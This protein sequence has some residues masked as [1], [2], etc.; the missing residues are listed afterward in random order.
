MG[1][2]DR[3]HGSVTDGRGGGRF[4]DA[5]R[6]MFG[7]GDNFLNWSFPLYSA[8]G[9]RVRVHLLFVLVVIG[10]LVRSYFG[11]TSG[12]LGV[13]Y[14]AIGLASLFGLVL[15]HE[16]GHCIACRRV[17][18]EA[19][20][21]L[22]WPLGGLASCRPPHD[23]RSH[24]TTTI[25]GPAVNALLFPILGGIVLALT[26]NW[27]AVLFNP[28]SPGLAIPDVRLA[29]SQLQPMWLISLWWLYFMNAALLG[30]NLLPMYPL[31]GG[32]IVQEILWS[33]VGFR[34]SMVIA[35]K[36]GLIGAVVLGVFAVVFGNT[37]LMGVALFA[38]LTCW[39]QGRQIQFELAGEVPGYDFE[40][41][42][43]GMPGAEEEVASG[44][45][46][47]KR[48]EREEAEQTELDR[49]LAKIAKTGMGNLSTK[50]KKFLTRAT[51][52]KRRG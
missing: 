37:L 9:I 35:A 7:E 24:L 22:L 2:E 45:A 50:E 5:L 52:Q 51:D 20:Q 26:G 21:I 8:W 46:E 10:E 4:R 11:N 6:R 14:M 33:R 28:F 43:G 23:W 36:S 47:A 34:S 3:Q 13:A 29:T 40:R 19:D 44:R 49:I 38:G 41:G 31:D 39:M 1:W 48:R 15:L 12:S 27:H 16:Y 32:R 30:F 42:Y 25:G 17:R 18:G